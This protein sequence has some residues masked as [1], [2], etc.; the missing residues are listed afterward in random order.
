MNIISGNIDGGKPFDWGRASSDYA[1]YRD[2]YPEE[3]FL[4]IVERHLCIDGQTVLDVG[5]GTGVLPRHMYRYGAKWTA[6]DISE[7]QI[8]QAKRLSRGADIDYSATP[9][10]SIDYPDNTFD[11]ITACQCF[12]YFDH[13]AVMPKF[14]SLLKDRGS[15]LI[16]YMAWL[17]ADD[18][19]ADA[20]EKL[21]LKYSPCW[22]GAGET[23]RPIEIPALYKER[24][25]IVHREEWLLEVPFT[26]ERW[27]GRMRASRPVSASLTE[28]ETKL[29]DREHRAL[30]DRI[31][32]ERFA[33]RH[34]AAIAQ[35]RK[36]SVP[37][38]S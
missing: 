24:F 1:M 4:R 9:A 38:H 34:Y 2:I 27:H 22:S 25:D 7:R 19:I 21:A 28:A 5:T 20:S 18:P 3:F 26:R 8:E 15:L 6:V 10:Q 33:V 16:L 29:W 13:D 12:W 14:H 11:V 17:P 30:L 32:P 37:I 23:K 35:L 31:A 36:R